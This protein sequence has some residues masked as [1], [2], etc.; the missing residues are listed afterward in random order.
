M[1]FPE[2]Y[3]SSS[4]FSHEEPESEYIRE[5]F[6]FLRWFFGVCL[7]KES[8]RFL[9][10]VFKWFLH[11]YLGAV[12]VGF[13]FQ[14]SLPAFFLTMT[15]SFSASYVG[16]L[17]VYFVL[18][19]LLRREGEKIPR[20]PTEILFIVWFVLLVVSTGLTLFSSDFQFGQ[21]YSVI[22]KNSFA[23]IVFRIGLFLR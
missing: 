12:I 18:K 16:A 21:M 3:N 1:A 9:H 8:L 13:F 22:L 2:K 4:G 10:S 7:R 15:E 14:S 20:G 19:E 6:A 23:A 17:G 11:A 5:R